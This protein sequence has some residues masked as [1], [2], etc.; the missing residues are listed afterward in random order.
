M[1]HVIKDIAWFERVI[2]LLQSKYTLVDLG[3][4]ED[5][6]NNHKKGGVCHIT[7]DDGEKSFYTMAYPIL[8]K[9][10]VPATIFV[11]PKILSTQ[12]N[13]WFQEIE[14]YEQNVM[15][16]ILSR[17][18][19]L[20]L[21]TINETPFMDV[22]KCLPLDKIKETI[23]LY[24]KETK[25][26][27]KSRQNMNLDEILEVEKS[28]LITI[29]AHTLNHPILKNESDNNCDNEITGSI[30]ELEKMLGH[31]IR[32]FAYPNGTPKI[33]FGDREINCLK[34]NNIAIAV[35]TETKFVS[36]RDNKFALPRLGLSHGSISFVKL[37][38]LL[39]SNWE[40]IRSFTRHSE[41]KSRQKLSSILEQ[42][43][44]N[45]I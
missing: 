23:T 8:K 17:E 45:S 24:Q 6:S 42:I 39:G 41:T 33:D 27:P 26:P 22:L 1:F 32:Y 12:E 29:G 38:L 34:K 7:F 14:G 31:E 2:L 13:F 30:M 5:L 18:L 35:S 16:K 15:T 9:H 20:P 21:V 43:R 19:L 44:L 10:N 11:S 37:K 3:I 4:F 36:K 28:G 40:K 25:T